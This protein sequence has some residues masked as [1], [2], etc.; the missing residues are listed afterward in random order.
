MTLD[1][2]AGLMFHPPIG[3]GSKASCSKARP[4]SAATGRQRL[5][6]ERHLNHFN[7]Y[8]TPDARRPAEWHNRLQRL[9]ERRDSASR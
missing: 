8:V 7:I 3:I 4:R 9:A 2:K 6:V 5:V 1:E